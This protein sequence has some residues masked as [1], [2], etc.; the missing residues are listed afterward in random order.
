[1]S[2]IVQLPTIPVMYVA[3]VGGVEGISNAIA[4]IEDKLNHKLTGR[5][6]Y[7]VSITDKSGLHY[8]ACVAIQEGDDPTALDLEVSEIPGG[9]YAKG[10]IRPWDYRK[11]VPKLTAK[12]EQ[13][14]KEHKVDNTRPH[15]EFYRRHDDLILYLP[16]K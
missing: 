7:G 11:D 10:R 13:M 12:F 3:A 8:K 4:A 1:M 9:K 6:C 15:V 16:I 2:E 14:S 5:K